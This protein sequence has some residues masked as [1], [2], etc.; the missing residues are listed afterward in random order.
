MQEKQHPVAPP[1]QSHNQVREGGEA[2]LRPGGQRMRAKV[3]PVRWA[4]WW[5]RSFEPLKLA[6]RVSGKRKLF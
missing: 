3:V 4:A 6:K 1:A 2:R 5:D